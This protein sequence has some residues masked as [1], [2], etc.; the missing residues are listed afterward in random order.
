MAFTIYTQ[1][2]IA[3]Q[4]QNF[5]NDSQKYF[6]QIEQIAQK[7]DISPQD[8]ERVRIMLEILLDEYKTLK[9]SLLIPKSLKEK[10][11]Q[12]YIKAKTLYE[13]VFGKRD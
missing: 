11:K 6:A 3:K 10:A 8:K 4:W 9:P 7:N 13:K 2:Q 1:S 5:I 12:Q